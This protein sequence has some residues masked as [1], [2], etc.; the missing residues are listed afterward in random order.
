MKKAQTEIIGLMVLVI[1]FIFVGLIYI[2]FSG[3]SEESITRDVK[4][5]AKV[6]NLLKA[7]TQITPY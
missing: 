3:E 2:M 7:Y 4:Q 6:K 1:L 5:T